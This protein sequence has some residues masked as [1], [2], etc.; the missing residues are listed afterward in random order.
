MGRACGTY[1]I[2]EIYIKALMIRP[3]EKR[4]PGRLRRT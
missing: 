4:T 1:R 2:Q 3:E